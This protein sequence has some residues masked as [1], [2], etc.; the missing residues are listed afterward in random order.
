MGNVDDFYRL[1]FVPGFSHCQG[2][3]GCSDIDW[4]TA[5]EDWVEKGKAPDRLIGTR[6]VN[7]LSGWTRKR[8]RPVC[9]YPKVAKYKGSGSTDDAEN[10]VCE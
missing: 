7:Y 4:L 5:L 2:G 1:F 3:V 9:P 8:T 10:F 6:A